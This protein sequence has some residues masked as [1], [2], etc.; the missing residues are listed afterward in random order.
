MAES[1]QTLIVAANREVHFPQDA[2]EGYNAMK[3]MQQVPPH[4]S[5]GAIF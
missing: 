2:E 4:S 3:E 5:R 1:M